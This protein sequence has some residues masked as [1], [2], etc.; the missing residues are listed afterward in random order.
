MTRTL[1]FSLCTPP[2]LPLCIGK[3][4]DIVYGI[5]DGNDDGCFG[6]SNNGTIFTVKALD[7]EV[8]S[9]YNLF[10]MAKDQAESPQKQLSSTIQVNIILKDVNDNAP[11]FVT[12]NETAIMENIPFNTVVM[13][14]KAI[15]KDEGRNSY[16]EYSLASTQD[17]KFVIGP[18]DGLLRVNGR[19]D[20]ETTP[21]YVLRV[22][23]KDRGYPTTSTTT[24]ILVR[25]LDEN[26]NG[27]IFDPVNY[28]AAV[29]E[30]ASTG[31]SVL[32]VSA[33][34]Q[35]EGLNGRLRYSVVAGDKN[36]D[37]SI[38]ED[39][40]IVRV[41]NDLDYE[42]KSTYVLTVQVE[43]GGVDV[44]YDSATVTISITDCNDNPP[45]FVNSPYV[46]HIMEGVSTPPPAVVTTVT[47]V[48]YDTPPNGQVRY[49]L[50]DGDQGLFQIN[51]TTGEI[52]VHKALDRET[53][54]TYELVVIAMDSGK[55]PPTFLYLS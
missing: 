8:Q 45:V 19:L 47:A 43:D 29:A 13:A 40:G 28:S 2:Y 42:T 33:T 11:E 35:D 51:G 16:V 5:V 23:A 37:F 50:K 46:V 18:V 4:G 3:N 34:D 27:P 22:T 41:V 15:D 52:T 31:L 49:F 30:N 1:F 12:P 32:Q 54:D 20:R 53:E 38:S 48:D 39:T 36:H 25:V 24:D 44:R 7:R 14:V 10:V 17:P 6:I 26:D 21:S 9:F 55:S